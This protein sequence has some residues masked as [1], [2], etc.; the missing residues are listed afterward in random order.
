MG[1]GTTKSLLRFYDSDV[2]RRHEALKRQAEAVTS[3]YRAMTSD[4]PEGHVKTET[5]AADSKS[6]FAG[7][8]SGIRHSAAEVKFDSTSVVKRETDIKDAKVPLASHSIAPGQMTTSDTTDY[9]ADDDDVIT[10]PSSVKSI[11]E[12]EAGNSAGDATDSGYDL[13]AST[14]ISLSSP[15]KSNKDVKK[16]KK[17]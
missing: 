2:I 12:N 17:P 15:P 8:G 4:E 13:V 7:E 3:Q 16:K 5:N 1:V 14:L 6:W 10:E 9:D 11:F